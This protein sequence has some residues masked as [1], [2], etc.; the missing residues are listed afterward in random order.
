MMW[1]SL[2]GI[3]EKIAKFFVFYQIDVFES[4]L[5]DNGIILLAA[6]IHYF[7]VGG[8]MRLFEK[9]MQVDK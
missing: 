9:E 8:G 7:G 4:C 6:K 1:K 5:E 2:N 3:N